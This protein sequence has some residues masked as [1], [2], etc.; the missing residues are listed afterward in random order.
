M[1]IAYIN[2]NA[3]GSMTRAIVMTAQKALPEAEV[4][5]LTNSGGPAAIE[6]PADGRA[7]V[8][9]VLDCVARAGALGADAIVIACFDDTGLAEARAAA[10]C[11]VLGIGQAS[12]M[13]AVLLGLRFAVVTSVAAAIPVIEDNIETQGFAALRASV[14]AS[15]LPV[16][17]IDE[18]APDTVDHLAREIEAARVKDG[19]GCVILGCAGMSPLKA[20]LGQRAAVPLID[21]VAASAVLARA[22]VAGLQ[23]AS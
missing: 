2:P 13:M 18:G 5:G 12:Y 6:G 19:A 7:A 20:E 11:P 17:V 22:A 10:K 3:T 21:G 16:L 14:R 1:K 9:G 8:P 23:A 4:L 15:G